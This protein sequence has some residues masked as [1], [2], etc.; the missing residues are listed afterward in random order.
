M[1]LRLAI[2]LVVWWCEF[3]W[4]AALTKPII[5]TMIVV[6]VYCNPYYPPLEYLHKVFSNATL[7]PRL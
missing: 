6:W 4:G 3:W 7:K 1:Q 2:L 5:H